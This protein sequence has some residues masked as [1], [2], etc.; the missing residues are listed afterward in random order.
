MFSSH[1][2][3]ALK[4]PHDVSTDNNPNPKVT[5]IHQAKD[6]FAIF[7]FG[8][9]RADKIREEKNNLSQS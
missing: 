7:W 9:G 2:L 4:S 5:P 8:N 3:A 1:C 6:T